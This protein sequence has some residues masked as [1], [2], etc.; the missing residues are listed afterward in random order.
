MIKR[1]QRGTELDLLAE[2]EQALRDEMVRLE[3]YIQGGAEKERAEQINTMPA[4][5][6]LAEKRRQASFAEQV[7]SK[8]EIRNIKRH[9]TK[10]TILFLMLLLAI[11]S[12]GSWVYRAYTDYF[13]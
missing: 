1:K 10:G 12:L 9:Q 6:E 11:L 13:M 7:L 2:K 5:D 4:P 8:K 3:A